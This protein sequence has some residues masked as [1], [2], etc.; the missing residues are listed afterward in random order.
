MNLTRRG[1]LGMLGAAIVAPKLLP[2]P[3]PDPASLQLGIEELES[4]YI[5]PAMVQLANQIDGM[6]MRF[7]SRYDPVSDTRHNR[8][9]VLTGWP[10]I[11]PDKYSVRIQG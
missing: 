11:V 2:A 9:D 4:A 7:V 5:R 3:K 1:L 10:R 6:A 8:I